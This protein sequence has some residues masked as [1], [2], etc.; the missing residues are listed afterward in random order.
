MTC[1]FSSSYNSTH[2]Q[3]G[4]HHEWQETISALQPFLPSLPVTKLFRFLEH[5]NVSPCLASGIWE[6]IADPKDEVPQKP[7]VGNPAS[8]KAVTQN[9]QINAVSK[10]HLHT[11]LFLTF[12]NYHLPLG[13]LFV[14]DEVL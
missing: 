13:E 8:L 4:Q 1:L 11:K 12:L 10:S 6:C 7:Q 5:V 2:I 14:R 3:W 9:Y